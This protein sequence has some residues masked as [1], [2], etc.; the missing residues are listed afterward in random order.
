M[1][2]KYLSWF[3]SYLRKT[4]HPQ[5]AIFFTLTR[6]GGVNIWP[7][8]VNS[9][10]IGPRTSQGFVWFSSHSFIS[11]RGEMAWEWP[12]ICFLGRGNS[13]CGRG[14]GARFGDDGPR[15]KILTV[16]LPARARLEATSGVNERGEAVYGA[17]HPSV[18]LIFSAIRAICFVQIQIKLAKE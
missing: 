14:L 1:Q 17:F 9:G 10:T 7:K 4:V 6:A 2:N 12:P 5:I 16:S 13:M 11:I 8:E 3:E 15:N 18:R